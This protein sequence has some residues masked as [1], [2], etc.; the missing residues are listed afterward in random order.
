MTGAP[1]SADLFV[2]WSEEHGA[3]WAPNELGYTR[4]LA[5]AGRYSE[6]RAKELVAAANWSPEIFH[7]IAIR[8]PMHGAE[9]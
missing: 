9:R 3:W 4:E 7:E 2:I 6:R 5:H 8:D 1:S